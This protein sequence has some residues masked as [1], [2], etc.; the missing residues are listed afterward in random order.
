MALVAHARDVPSDPREVLGDTFAALPADPSRLLV[1]TCHRVELYLVGD[2]VEPLAGL[3][4]PPG[5]TRYDD[6]DAVRHLLAV[7]CGLD[8][9]V[10][11]ETQVLHQFREAVEDGRAEHGLD[12]VLDRLLQVALRAGR[13]ARTFVTGAPRSLADAALD[14]IEQR[15]STQRQSAQGQSPSSSAHDEIL[16]VGAGRMA[17]LAALAARRRGATVRVAN[18]TS[19]RAAAL[20]AE[21]G[22]SEAPFGSLEGPL[23]GGVILALAGRWPI[24]AVGLDR[25]AGAGTPIVDLSSP[26]ALSVEARASLGDTFVSVDD[27][28]NDPDAGPDARLRLRL[29]RLISR[30][31]GDFCQ[32]LRSRDAVPAITAVVSHAEAR[33]A[34]ELAWLRRRLPDLDE[35]QLG[36]VEQMSHRLVAA[37]LHEP[38]AALTNDDGDLESAARALFGL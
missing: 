35:E 27:L 38:L 12:P 22:G 28:A 9:A 5:T 32:W 14:R 33:R 15:R 23:P 30:A 20:A 19:E 6:V 25:L 24:D 29:E 31:G 13:E 37:L 18:R 3:E 11:G 8:S 4:L 16:V 2:D 34:E 26:P 21:V 17:R 1:R 7:A 10:F 36:V